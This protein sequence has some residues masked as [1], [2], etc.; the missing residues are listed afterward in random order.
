MWFVSFV[1]QFVRPLMFFIS[2]VVG[3]RCVRLLSGPD[4]VVSMPTA[5]SG[6]LLRAPAQS[7][8]LH[9]FAAI[10]F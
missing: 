1:R 7:A 10:R 9:T 6:P 8:F 5:P 3:A 2:F 4:G